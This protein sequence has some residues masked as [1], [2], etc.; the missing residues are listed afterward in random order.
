MPDEGGVAGCGGGGGDVGSV[1]DGGGVVDGGGGGGGDAC[2][3]GDGDVVEGTCCWNPVQRAV[4][5]VDHGSVY[6]NALMSALRTPQP[7]L[8]WI[9]S[10]RYL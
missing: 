3:G 1:G 9:R 2:V 4:D 7:I 10:T 5:R 8:L 6:R